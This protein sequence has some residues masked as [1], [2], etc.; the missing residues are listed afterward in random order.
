MQSLLEGLVSSAGADLSAVSS[1]AAAFCD[2][3]TARVSAHGA[4]VGEAAS[5]STALLAS[6]VI[7][8]SKENGAAKA[9]A[10]ASLSRVEQCRSAAAAELGAVG[11]AVEG[12]RASLM[13]TVESVCSEVS[14]AIVK[15]CE[16]VDQTSDA[17]NTILAQVKSATEGMTA[18]AS[19]AM[20]GF[21]GFL[22]TKGQD[23]C[24]GVQAHFSSVENRL[25]AQQRGVQS[26]VV[27]VSSFADAMAVAVVQPTGTTPRKLPEGYTA[28]AELESTRPHKDIKD[29]ARLHLLDGGSV[30]VPV[31]AGENE[32]SAA[33]ASL[34]L[35]A[36]V[37]GCSADAA[38]KLE[39]TPLPPP[40]PAAAKENAGP[41]VATASATTRPSGLA[42]GALSRSKTASD[43]RNRT[44]SSSSDK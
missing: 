2:D 21:K 32:D 20:D 11:A 22:D 18:S 28:L 6:H 30:P 5:A 9:K 41:N 26:V 31:S 33:T 39:V 24:S 37:E 10:E 25:C 4:S 12:K 29:E 1:S 36:P 23:V 19:S 14:D 16:S 15:G 35:P 27:Q 38:D 44:A 42:K 40:P 34:S 8:L 7:E 13:H 3:A 17:A 43:M